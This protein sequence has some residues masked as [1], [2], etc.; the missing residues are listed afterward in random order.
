MKTT[1]QVINVYRLMTSFTN[2]AIVDFW[3]NRAS[4]NG[5]GPCKGELLV[6]PTS[7]NE[8]HASSV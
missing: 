4:K 8:N 1:A 6:Q 3:I 5:S 7:F 2:T